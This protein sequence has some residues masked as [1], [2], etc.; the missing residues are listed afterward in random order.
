MLFE[1]IED[2]VRAISDAYDYPMFLLGFKDGTTFDNVGEAKK[3]LYQDAIIPE[4]IG[5]AEAFARYFELGKLGLKIEITYDHLEIFQQSEKDKAEA[6]KAK[7]EANMPLLTNNI[8]TLNQF[9]TAIDYDARGPEGDKLLSDIQ[10]MPLAVKLQ[11]GG[12]Q[13]MQAILT[14][15]SIPDPRK[16]QILIVLFGLSEQD[17]NAIMNAK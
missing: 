10:S 4:A 5:W 11:V 14:D 17:A 6:L 8:I 16:R 13:A 3:T 7:I 2:D 1:E 15:V 12:T 9:L